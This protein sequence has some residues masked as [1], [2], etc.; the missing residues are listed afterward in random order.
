M[1]RAFFGIDSK[2]FSIVPD[3]RFLY[4]SQRH[5]EALAHLI[6][7]VKESGGCAMLTGDVGTG[8]TLIS[9]CLIA[10]LGENIEVALC[11]NPRVTDIEFLANICDEFGISYPRDGASRKE[12]VDLITDHL[13]KVYAAGWRVVVI[14]D[15]AQDLAPDVLEQ[16]RLLTN[17]ETGDTKPLQIVLIGQQELLEILAS[18]EMRQV[19][20]KITARYHLTPLSKKETA[21]YIDHRL[22][23]AGMWQ[24]T[25][26]RGAVSEIYKSSGGIPRLINVICDRALLGAYVREKKTVTRKLARIAASEVS[27]NIANR[28][29]VLPWLAG[30]VAAALFAFVLVDPFGMG[31]SKA[32]WIARAPASIRSALPFLHSASSEAVG[33]VPAVI[34]ESSAG[35]LSHGAAGPE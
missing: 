35:E 12:M 7:G 15:E 22:S 3:E 33:Q 8:K 6:Y 19:A 11:L 9:R 1:Y 28:R 23:V 30:A 34:A 14:I 31:L 4:M 29:H 25:F 21:E 32:G 24:G 27:G 2:P 16:V 5:R 18:T 13:L 20:Q 26:R 10:G 17:L